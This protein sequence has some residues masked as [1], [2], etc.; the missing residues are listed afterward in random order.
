MKVK[1]KGLSSTQAAL[2]TK[3]KPA[4]MARPSEL[5]D[6]ALRRTGKKDNF[7]TTSV[8]RAF[9]PAAPP[10]AAPID[11]NKLFTLTPQQ[12]ALLR[13]KM[14]APAFPLPNEPVD[15]KA[16]DPVDAGYRRA[17]L[18]STNQYNPLSRQLGNGERVC[19]GAAIV[20][21]LILSSD[22][23][24]RC[25]QNA[26]ALRTAFK[27]LEAGATLPPGLSPAQIETS[28]QNFEQG[29]LSAADVAV[30]QQAAYSM[31]RSVQRDPKT[32]VAPDDGVDAKSMAIVL[33]QLQGDGAAMKDAK[34][35]LKS[36]SR[37]HGHWVAQ[38]NSRDADSDTQKTI[39]WQL[40]PESQISVDSAPRG[41]VHVTHNLKSKTG[42]FPTETVS[43][44][45]VHVIEGSTTYAV[46]K[47]GELFDQSRK[48]E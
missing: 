9:S 13:D 35:T 40:R 16:A 3:T 34:F 27:R 14:G 8:S 1:P 36:D 25:Q 5:S 21:A 42:P 29:S 46:D 45:Q 23:P 30:L 17:L 4:D 24:Q 10:R 44:I 39:P 48:V 11:L 18:T 26:Q 6:R 28:I 37:G 43:P 20:N 2:T 12:G 31:L 7:S 41:S 32:H 19:G 33:S 38:A 15:L 22:S 47:L